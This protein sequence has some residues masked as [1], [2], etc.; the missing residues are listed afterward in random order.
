MSCLTDNVPPESREVELK[1]L[2]Q[3]LDIAEY[4]KQQARYAYGL[5]GGDAVTENAEYVLKKL[6]ANAVSE[7]TGRELIH[8][9]RKF[10]T[11]DEL[12]QPIEILT[13]HGYLRRK[14]QEYVK[15]RKPQVIYEVNPT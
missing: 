12:S 7:I 4:Y 14:K 9:C 8:L 15:G 6:R 5:M 13:E 11:M 2:G 3:A 1:T 10:R